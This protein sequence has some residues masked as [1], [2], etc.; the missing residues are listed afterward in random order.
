MKFYTEVNTTNYIHFKADSRS[1]GQQIQ[2]F[3]KANISCLLANLRLYSDVKVRK[4][5]QSRYRPGVAE[6]VPG[7]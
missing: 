4:G 5:K 1:D 3:L 2:L 7:S 6:W